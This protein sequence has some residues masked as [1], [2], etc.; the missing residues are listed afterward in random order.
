M[1]IMQIVFT[2]RETILI[3]MEDSDVSVRNFA[4]KYIKYVQFF[5]WE[6]ESGLKD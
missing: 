2:C 6:E 4:G 5:W 3:L 1:L